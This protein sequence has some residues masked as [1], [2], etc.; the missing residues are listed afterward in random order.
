MVAAIR[1]RL[2]VCDTS[3]IAFIANAEIMMIKIEDMLIMDNEMYGVL[4]FLDTLARDF[5]KTSLPRAKRFLPTA[6]R[7]EVLLDIV[8]LPTRTSIVITATMPRYL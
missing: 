2:S 7:K 1:K 3:F 8:E 5:G 6:L 4:Y